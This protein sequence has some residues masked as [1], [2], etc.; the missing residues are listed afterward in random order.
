ME[1]SSKLVEAAVEEFSKLPGIG[2]KTALRL[3]LHLLKQQKSDV[4]HFGNAFINLR[5]NIKYCSQCYNISDEETCAICKNKNRNHGLI[6]VVEDLR[7]V[8]AIEN[9]AQFNG[10]FH[11]LNGL[12]SPIDGVGPEDLTIKPL[13]NRIKNNAAEEL[14]FALSATMEGDTTMF[15]ISRQLKETNIKIS[16][17][18]RGIAIGGELEYADEVT[19]GRSISDRIPYHH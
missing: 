9:T 2:Q 4:D 7:D 13:I 11:V 17:I 8:I 19:L 18:A 5:N 3:V 6:C 12:I 14:I 1:F 10:V 15:Y 16:S